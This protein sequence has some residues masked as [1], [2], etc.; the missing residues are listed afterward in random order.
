MQTTLAW[1]SKQGY[2]VE[3]SQQPPP[4]P[5]GPQLCRAEGSALYTHSV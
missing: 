3:A 4:R 2:K 5:F 1:A